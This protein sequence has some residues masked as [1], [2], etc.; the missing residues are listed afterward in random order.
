MVSKLVLLVPSLLLCLGC[1]TIVIA[2][3]EVT[4]SPESIE[5]FN[6]L[7]VESSTDIV[8]ETLEFV[9]STNNKYQKVEASFTKSPLKQL[10]DE[11][12]SN[13]DINKIN[14]IDVRKEYIDYY[15]ESYKCMTKENCYV[16]TLNYFQTRVS[17][18]FYVDAQPSV[19]QGNFSLVITPV[20]KDLTLLSIIGD[21][22]SVNLGEKCCSTHTL[23]KYLDLYPVSTA[24]L[25]EYRIILYVKDILASRHIKTKLINREILSP[26][27]KKVREKNKRSR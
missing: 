8:I 24:R 12:N 1:S 25:D 20:H 19:M 18:S 2:K 4:S 17:P 15:Y 3:N 27:G 13:F 23:Q 5:S 10:F 7:R 9:F 11:A 21:D 26:I 16:K 6:T 22:L 14:I